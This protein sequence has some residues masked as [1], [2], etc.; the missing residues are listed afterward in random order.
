MV[1]I[2]IMQGSLQLGATCTVWSC[3]AYTADATTPVSIKLVSS[4]Y[5]LAVPFSRAGSKINEMI[6]LS[7]KTNVTTVITVKIS[8]M[9]D[10]KPNGIPISI[11]QCTITTKKLQLKEGV[12]LIDHDPQLVGIPC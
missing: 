8:D 7:T 4:L 10:I 11:S 9:L 1:Q 12:L 2:V 3:S 5:S 6:N